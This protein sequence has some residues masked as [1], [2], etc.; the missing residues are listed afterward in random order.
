M[1]DVEYE[2]NTGKILTGSVDGG[3]KDDV[4]LEQS[5]YM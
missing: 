3:W 1:W 5:K 4:K 2:R